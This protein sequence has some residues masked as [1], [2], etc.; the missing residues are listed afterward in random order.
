MTDI[1]KELTDFMRFVVYWGE[2]YQPNKTDVVK[3]DYFFPAR[4]YEPEDIEQ[5]E[6][7]AVGEVV[8]LSAVTQ[9]HFIL[10]VA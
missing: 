1:Y 10:R 9:I 7:M 2:G 4:G 5:I 3:L 8:N 6:N